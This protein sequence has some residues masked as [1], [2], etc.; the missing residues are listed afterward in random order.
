MAS[1][2][3]SQHIINSG[4]DHFSDSA[5][6]TIDRWPTKPKPVDPL[7]SRTYMPGFDMGDWLTLKTEE[8]IYEIIQVVE[9]TTEPPSYFYTTTD[10]D[11][12][13]IKFKK[14]EVQ[15]RPPMMSAT[16]AK[17]FLRWN[18]YDR[19]TCVSYKELLKEYRPLTETEKLLY[20]KEE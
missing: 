18:L 14:I 17:N 6:Y 9:I 2:K 10:R 12:L 16:T 3:K 5:R 19:D 15:E 4:F 20:A 7:I 1:G 13:Y 8:P 11:D